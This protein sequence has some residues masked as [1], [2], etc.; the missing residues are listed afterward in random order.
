MPSTKNFSH[1]RNF[2]PPYHQAHSNWGGFL[3]GSNSPLD[4]FLWSQWW[5]LDHLTFAHQLPRF[6]SLGNEEES[7]TRP[8]VCSSSLLH[9]VKM[10]P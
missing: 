2:P 7:G 10:I 8:K 6:E 1:L 4:V 3:Q 5:F 9:K